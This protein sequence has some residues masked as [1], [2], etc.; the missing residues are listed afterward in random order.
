VGD[1]EYELRRG[2]DVVATGRLQLEARPSPGDTLTLGSQR[3][4]VVDVLELLA[5]PRLILSI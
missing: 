2:D 5:G 1:Y 3:V 4:E